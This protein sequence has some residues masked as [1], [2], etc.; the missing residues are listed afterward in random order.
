MARGAERP[1]LAD[2]VARLGQFPDRP[3]RVRVVGG[4]DEQ[5]RP[6]PVLAQGRLGAKRPVVQPGREQRQARESIVAGRLED[7]DV[8]AN[9]RAE[10]P[11]G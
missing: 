9:R 6:R 1:D 8:G 7:G 10:E 4:R 3:Q 5:G 11:D 2:A